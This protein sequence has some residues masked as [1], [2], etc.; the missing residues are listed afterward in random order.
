MSNWEYQ[1]IRKELM[2]KPKATIR[3]KNKEIEVLTQQ[4]AD[5][6]LKVR[7][8]VL[9]THTNGRQLMTIEPANDKGM[10]YGFGL[11]NQRR[12]RESHCRYAELR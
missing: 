12:R 8:F 11:L 10:K 6:K 3:S 7:A 5:F 9:A 2:K 1:Q 4:F